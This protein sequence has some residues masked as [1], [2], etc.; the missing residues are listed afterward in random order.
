[1]DDLYDVVVKEFANIHPKL[2]AGIIITKSYNSRAVEVNYE[3]TWANG[4]L[5]MPIFSIEDMYSGTD[6]SK[7]VWPKWE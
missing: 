6:I 4:E 3:A 7:A 5:G 2:K 1:M